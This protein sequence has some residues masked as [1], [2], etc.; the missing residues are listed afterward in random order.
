MDVALVVAERDRRLN[1]LAEEIAELAAHIHAATYRL[2]RLVAAFDDQA[3]WHG[4]KTCAHAT[5]A[6]K[7]EPEADGSGANP[8][9]ELRSEP[10]ISP[11]QRRAAALVLL[12]DS[13]VAAGLP[14]RRAAD[15]RHV[16][17]HVD[18]ACVERS[19][20][21]IPCVDFRGASTVA[22]SR[23]ITFGIGPAEA[24][25]VS[26]TSCTCVRFITVSCT[27]AGFGSRAARVVLGRRADDLAR[28]IHETP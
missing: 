21:A 6:P 14:G 17:V 16:V 26:R 7:R 19:R 24:R 18:A 3:G 15:T 10:P 2:L 12:A 13:A 28:I 27:R 9:G 5:R 11:T 25:R 20:I 1:E 23:R 22:F 8:A 4:W